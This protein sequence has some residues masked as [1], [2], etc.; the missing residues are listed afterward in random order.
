M[1][2]KFDVIALDADD[3]LWHNENIY[4]K[5][6]EKFKQLLGRYHTKEWI[7]K[8]LYQTELRNLDF[9]G[10]GIK[11][12][13]LSMIETAIELSEGRVT[14]SEIG[15][16]LDF[17]KAMMATPVEVLDHVPEVLESLAPLYS[18]ML[19]TKGDLID[20]R[21]KLARSGLEDYFDIKEVVSTKTAETY[22]SLFE[23]HQIEPSRFLMVGN[24]LRSDI[25]PVLENGGAA[26]YIPYH[27]TWAHE[28]VSKSEEEQHDYYQLSGI[29]QLPGFLKKIS[30]S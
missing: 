19:I 24:S 27:L 7:D 30:E 20:Q 14:G 22:R 15:E 29:D 10:Y 25:L 18:I 3:T 16:I 1:M 21:S 11:S 2:P 9:Y 6:Q 5:T 8:R 12:F 26:V 23:R 17:G 4:T 13:T 28:Q